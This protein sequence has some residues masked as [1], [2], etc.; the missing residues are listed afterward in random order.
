MHRYPAFRLAAE[1]D[2]L[3][4]YLQD[5]PPG[6]LLTYERIAAEC[7]CLTRSSEPDARNLY[8]A[9]MIL[10]REHGIY[11]DV[12]TGVGIVRADDEAKVDGG[13]LHR[14]RLE[15]E[16]KRWL[17]RTTSVEKFDNLPYTKQVSHN[18]QVISAST[19]AAA[20]SLE[21]VRKVEG[22]VAS[23]GKIEARPVLDLM[24]SIGRIGQ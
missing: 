2:A 1:T 18:A 10:R 11:F 9:R 15:A 21:S 16:S 8:S 13:S 7:G 24:A 23:A 5:K 22:E 12:V 20:A 3:I 14:R 4:R 19:I 17:S 6:E